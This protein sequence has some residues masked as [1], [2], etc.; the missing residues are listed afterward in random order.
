M[1]QPKNLR[2]TQNMFWKNFSWLDFSIL[3]LI[4][5][6]S[7]LIGYTSLPEQLH[8]GYKMLLSIFIFILSSSLL[9]YSSK[10]SCRVYVLII[11]MIKFWFSVKKYNNKKVSPKYLVPYDSIVENRFV[12]TKKGKNDSKYLAVLKFQGKSPWNKDEEDKRAFLAKFTDLLD[13]TDFHISFI[14]KKELMDYSKNF[15]NI[16]ENKNKK[17]K[18]LKSQKAPKNVRDNYISYYKEVIDDF[19]ALDTN[20]LVDIYYI[21]LYAKNTNELEK[22]VYKTINS[23]NSMEIESELVQGIDLI[24]FLG[25]LND[26]EVDEELAK[27]Y[28]TQQNEYEKQLF[29]KSKRKSYDLDET[30]FEFYKNKI[31]SIFAKKTKDKTKVIKNVKKKRINLDELISNEQIIFKS[32][33]FIRDKKYCS[34]HTISELPLILPERWADEIFKSDSTIVW[35][36][37]IFNES[38]QASLLDKTGKKMTDNSTMIKSKYYQ[39]SS[40][41]QLEALEYLENQLQIDRNVLTNSS[42][43]IINT[44]DSLRELRELEAENVANAKRNKININPV[45]FKQFEAL[46]QS[47]LITTNNLKENIPMSSHNVACSWPFENES[48]NDGNMLLLGET[49]STGEPIIF[50]QFYKNNPRRVNYNMFTVGSSGKGKSTDVKKAIVSNLAQ[51]NKVYVIDPQNEYSKLGRKFGASIIDLGLGINTVINPLE[52]QLLLLEDEKDENNEARQKTFDF[53][54]NENSIVKSIINSHFNWLK[55]FFSLINPDW[56]N[57]DLVLVMNFVKDLYTNLGLYTIKTIKQLK[58][59]KYP[60]ISDLIRLI[61]NYEFISDFDKRRKQIKLANIVDR[62]KFDFEYNGRYEMLYNGQTNLDL[63]NDFII[64]NTQYSSDENSDEKIGLYVLLSFIQNK[65]FNNIIEDP[66]RNTVLVIDELHKYIDPNNPT[67]LD[68]VYTM[69]KTVRKFNAGMI[70]CTQNPS[71]FLGSSM[72]TKKAEAILGNC[73]YSKF[74]GLRQADLDAVNEMFKHNGGLNNTQRSHL[75]DSEIGKLLFSLHTYSKIKMNIHYNDFEKELFFTK[76]EIGKIR[77][78]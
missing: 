52:V 1:L 43:M 63:N 3:S 8:Q 35:N 31:K 38:I 11:R 29:L 6:G 61:E 17:V 75:S 20:L 42:L 48:S 26:K 74:F 30:F 55:K 62:L 16:I 2:K 70:L 54:K 32:N 77:K 15:L 72:I 4:I 36:L 71:D 44:A 25:S 65:I 53:K 14:R 47:C 57:D 58:L 76:G 13:S 18:Y 27:L 21:A 73:Q 45:T 39:K 59:F 19:K 67:T 23:F 24:K 10:Y 41:L 33:Y 78:E 46:A 34:I 12:K 69:T 64:F 7:I 28:L 60:I 49:T 56:S 68:F 5:V 9:I 40:A 66:N 22:T 50:D 51:N 37:S